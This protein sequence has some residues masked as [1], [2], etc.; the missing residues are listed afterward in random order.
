MKAFCFSNFFFRFKMR[1]IISV[2][3]RTDI[4]AF[5][6]AWFRRRL[7]KG[8]VEVSNPFSHKNE[9]ISLLPEDVYGFVFWSRYPKPLLQHFDYIDNKFSHNH[10]LHLTLNDYPKLLEGNNPRSELVLRSVDLFVQRYGTKYIIWRFDPI[11][12]S[13]YT[14]INWLVYKFEQLCSKLENKVENCITSFVDVYAKV[15]RNFALLKQKYGFELVKLTQSE[16]KEII[17]RMQEI[18]VKYGISLSLCCEGILADSLSLSTASC[19]NPARFSN[20]SINELKKFKIVPSRKDCTC[21]ESKD[22]GFYNSCLF[23]CRYCYAVNSL[24]KSFRKYFLI[25]K[26]N[27]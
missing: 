7:E 3:R 1:R 10:Y 15:N 22:I 14:P 8:F 4:P 5:Y 21:I 11:I 26:L 6:S 24:E 13:N 18:A 23:G 9:I 16:Q 19:I 25:K 17:E 27:N 12:V 20:S 2:S